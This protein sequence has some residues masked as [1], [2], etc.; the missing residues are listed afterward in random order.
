MRNVLGRCWAVGLAFVMVGCTSD[1]TRCKTMCKWLD[2]CAE[3]IVNCTP[4][5]IDECV[6][7]AGELS[8]GCDDA[9]ADFTDCLDD[10]DLDCSEVESSCRSELA[11]FTDQCDGEFD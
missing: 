8:D 11:E 5:E 4:S 1:E 2:Q 3:A 10:H 6:R 7:E 9:F